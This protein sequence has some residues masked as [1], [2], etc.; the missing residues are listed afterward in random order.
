[1]RHLRG[2][3]PHS[4]PAH[5]WS[6][7]SRLAK[8]HKGPSL[9][10]SQQ[11]LSLIRGLFRQQSIPAPSLPSEPLS[12]RRPPR[13]RTAGPRL[14]LDPYKTGLSHYAKLFSFYA[15]MPMEKAALEMVEKW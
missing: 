6:Y 1:M 8:E 14:R 3:C 7:W 10:R 15:K 4:L 2:L 12:A 13:A 5:G 9:G 11:D